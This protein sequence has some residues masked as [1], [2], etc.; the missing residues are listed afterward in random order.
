M[1]DLFAPLI[2]SD[3]FLNIS[4]SLEIPLSKNTCVLFELFII[5]GTCSF[6]ECLKTEATEDTTDCSLISNIVSSLCKSLSLI[7]MPPKKATSSIMA[8]FI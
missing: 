6:V 1:I 8:I 7:L 5:T 2:I 4:D 3:A